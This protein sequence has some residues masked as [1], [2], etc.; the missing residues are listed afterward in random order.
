MGTYQFQLFLKSITYTGDNI[1]DDLS[2]SILALGKKQAFELK[3]KNGQQ[4]T[5]KP[6]NLIGKDFF[7]STDKTL[8]SKISIRVTELD[9]S[10]NDSGGTTVNHNIKIESNS[11][12]AFTQT[13]IVEE[14]DNSGSDEK[15]GKFVFDFYIEFPAI[16]SLRNVLVAVDGYE[17]AQQV[18]DGVISP[19]TKGTPTDLGAYSSSDVFISMISQHSSATNDQGGSE[20]EITVNA[21]DS[22][23]WAM[24][25]FGSNLNY[26][27][28]LYNGIFNPTT[29]LSHLVLHPITATNYLPDAESDIK[30]Y[31]NQ[32]YIAE[33]T[34]LKPGKE[35]QYTLSFALVDNSDG[36]I[37]GYF[38]WDPFINV[39]G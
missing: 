28:Y 26:T 2:V 21:G 39:S 20:L 9:P 34:V 8:Q 12:A 38:S 1:G 4:K 15:I 25:T 31:D 30:T 27:A 32:L 24:M 3:L 23:R 6:V 17:L 35:V 29:V 19:G 13:V 37:V 10:R 18:R 7:E 14:D 11:K 36:H 22:I 16:G 5:F 33:G